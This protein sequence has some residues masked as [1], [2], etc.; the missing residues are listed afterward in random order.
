M[1]KEEAYKI[2]YEDLKRTVYL[3]ESMMAKTVIKVLCMAY[4]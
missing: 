3:E 4:L 1:T 2:V